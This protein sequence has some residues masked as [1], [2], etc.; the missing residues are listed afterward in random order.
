[1]DMYQHD[2]ATRFQFVLRGELNGNGVQDLEHAWS[3]AKSTLAGKELVV[4]ISGITN[5]DRSG[6]D[7][8]SRMR[9]SGAR[10]TAALPSESEDFLQSLGVPMAAPRGRRGNGWALR[11]L[12][13]AGLCGG[14]PR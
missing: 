6:V 3:T 5:A 14:A 9:D 12:H 7:L 2:S 4:D 1:M 11:F 10:L 13:F 8:L